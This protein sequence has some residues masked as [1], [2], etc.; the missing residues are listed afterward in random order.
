MGQPPTGRIAAAIAGGAAALSVGFVAI[1]QQTA[2][3][4]GPGEGEALFKAHC[5][6]CHDP[7]VGRAPPKST[8]AGLD[9]LEV[10]NE[11]KNG[12]MRPM[13]TGLT[14]A[15]MGAI[16]AYVSPP[17]PQRTAAPP[18][19]PDP[20]KCASVK[21]FAIGPRDWTA[22]GHGLENHR[23]A[24]G[25]GPA[26]APQAL[27]LKWSFAVA[28]GKEGQPTVAGGRVFLTSFGGNGYALDAASGCL[29][30]RIDG[31]KSRTTIAVGPLKASPSG[32]AAF[33]GD[34]T[35]TVHAVDAETG[36]ELWKT[37]VETHPL[38]ILSGAPVLYK[39][40]VYVPVSSYE[41]LTASAATYPCCTFRGAVV[42]LDAATGQQLW[43][44]NTIPEAPAPSHKN[45]A[46]TQMYGPAGGAVWGSPTVD[47]KRGLVLVATGDSYTD[48]KENG[49]DAILAL[50]LATGAVKWRTQVTA[51]DNYLSGCETQAMVNCPTPL[52][53]DYDFGAPPILVTLADGHDI[54]LAGQKSG[55][56][57][58]LNP[59]TGAVLWKTQVG[60]GGPLGGVE[61]GMA[62]NGRQLFV[63]VSD[64]FMPS[65]PGR[66]G[67][68]AL[69]PA[70]GKELWFTPSPHLP[71]G[72]TTG[73]A[74][75]MN[76]VSAAPTAASDLIFAGDLDGRLRAYS[77]TT[78]KIVWEVDTSAG[79][80]ATING[81]A[82]P[83]GAIDGPAGPVAAEGM[84]F[85]MTGYQGSLGG[86]SD[87]VL[88]VYGR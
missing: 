45:S 18:P 60:H 62:T 27:K 26:V 7:A 36:K 30:W 59:D 85:V 14:D 63:G 87:S 58:G 3:P 72:W 28:G 74:V 22:W 38:S 64:A 29:I 81:G 40:R 66:P 83:G 42:A 25:D 73:G 39:N 61:F 5:A 48:V 43:K 2:P 79:S 10:F 67:L 4:P 76:G 19:P 31:A 78:G 84:L 54:V 51:D 15:Q 11:L 44:T 75:C 12:S 71:C 88:L 47:A 8:L 56:V 50:D 34:A 41:E 86:P 35:K 24:S 53:H 46:G 52:G 9:L 69:D 21:P 37:P 17:S 16:A 33:Y 68:A 55:I 1:A 77:A 23:D 80:F 13:A 6:G 49:S 57:Y 82:R 32:Y 65:P 70:T 20:P